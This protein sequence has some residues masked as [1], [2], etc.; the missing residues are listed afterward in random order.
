MQHRVKDAQHEGS[1][2]DQQTERNGIVSAIA[3]SEHHRWH[4]ST[5][6]VDRSPVPVT[7]GGRGSVGQPEDISPGRYKVAQ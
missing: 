2:R 7:R 1:K 3:T 5:F 4:Y 6:P